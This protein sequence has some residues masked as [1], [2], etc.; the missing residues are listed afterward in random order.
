M[1]PERSQV[2]ASLIYN[3]YIFSIPPYVQEKIHREVIQYVYTSW[4]S[5]SRNVAY[6]NTLVHDVIN[7]LH[8]EHWTDKQKYFYVYMER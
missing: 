3:I 6:L 2:F 1:K 4:T 8:Y 7:L 5:I